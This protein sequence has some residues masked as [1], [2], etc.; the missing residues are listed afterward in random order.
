MA[1]VTL[2]AEMEY[3]AGAANWERHESRVMELV[4]INLTLRLS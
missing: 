1:A 3:F 2:L 4:N